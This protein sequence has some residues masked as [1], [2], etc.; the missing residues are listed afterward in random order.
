MV[1]F[2][3]W[4]PV[5][6]NNNLREPI[7]PAHVAVSGLI[8]GGRREL[9]PS[10]KKKKKLKFKRKKLEEGNPKEIFQDNCYKMKTYCRLFTGLGCERSST[11]VSNACNA[12]L[13]GKA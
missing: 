1:S 2:S 6:I 4:C 5:K 11:T 12:E 9:D 8:E 7:G 3:M 10:K 13:A